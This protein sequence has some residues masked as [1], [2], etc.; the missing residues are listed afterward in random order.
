MSEPSTS[1]QAATVLTA[2]R[3]HP[4]HESIVQLRVEAV[5]LAIQAHGGDRPFNA[6][7][8]GED[9]KTDHEASD[10]ALLATARKIHVFLVKTP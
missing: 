2:L 9:G 4:V 8:R 5:A 3:M 10:E 1:E 6:R 7:I